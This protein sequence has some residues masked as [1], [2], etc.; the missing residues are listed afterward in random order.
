[1]G[2]GE[3]NAGGNPAMDLHPIQGGV[4]RWKY[5][6]SLYA[7]ETGISSS[8]INHS[9]YMQPLPFT[10]LLVMRVFVTHYAY[11]SY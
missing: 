4:E 10:I 1:M 8:L 3:F 2:S 5:S 11:H 7:I 9:A 6:W